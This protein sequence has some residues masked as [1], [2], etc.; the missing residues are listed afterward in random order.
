MFSRSASPVRF[1]A[2][3]SVLALLG[4]LLAA[5][6]HFVPP[7]PFHAPAMPQGRISV[8]LVPAPGIQS[9][10]PHI[11]TFGLP[12]P[13]ESMTRLG[14]STVRVFDGGEEIPAHVSEL[15]PYR[16]IMKAEDDGN[17]VRVARIQFTHA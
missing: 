14:L 11:V 2:R 1:N 12:W 13:R 4:F 3:Q 9:A 17:W 7:A 15:S 16:R 8:K 6:T 5:C 10:G